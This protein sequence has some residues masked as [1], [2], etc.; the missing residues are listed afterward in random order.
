MFSKSF[1]NALLP[2]SSL[3]PYI[4]LPITYYYPSCIR[5]TNIYFIT[6]YVAVSAVD[7]GTHQ[8]GK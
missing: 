4:F 6:Y 7:T 3:T 2:P 5:S 1:Q 8:G